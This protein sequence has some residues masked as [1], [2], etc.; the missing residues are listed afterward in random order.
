MFT[1]PFLNTASTGLF[2]EW[3]GG[4]D[5]RKTS[6]G[7]VRKV[8]KG[9]R[10]LLWN[11]LLK[12]AVCEKDL[13]ETRTLRA[14]TCK[15]SWVLYGWEKKMDSLMHHSSLFSDSASILSLFFPHVHHGTCVRY[16]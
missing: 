15:T 5:E 10:L 9:G 6:A 11:V 3:E 1:V 14:P 8:L 4:K 13:G 12:A 7:V 16:W 2:M